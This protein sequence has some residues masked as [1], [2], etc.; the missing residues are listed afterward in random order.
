MLTPDH[1]TRLHVSEFKQGRVSFD[2]APQR[3]E[4]RLCPLKSIPG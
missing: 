1:P 4:H 2:H 3:E